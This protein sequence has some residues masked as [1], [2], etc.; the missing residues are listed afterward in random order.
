MKHS[1]DLNI[2]GVGMG[3]GGSEKNSHIP[4]VQ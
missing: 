1:E 2:K 3:G 4:N